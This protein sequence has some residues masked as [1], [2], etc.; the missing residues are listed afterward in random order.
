MQKLKQFSKNKKKALLNNG[1]NQKDIVL[2]CM[3]SGCNGIN[4]YV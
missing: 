1:K 3:H 4:Q 2:L